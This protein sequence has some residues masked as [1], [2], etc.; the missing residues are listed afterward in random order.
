MK[1]LVC[2]LLGATML[3]G[4]AS[5]QDA[6]ELVAEA[7]IR[8]DTD[9]EGSARGLLR[10]AERS[11]DDDTDAQVRGDLALA[12]SQY[13]RWRR[14]WD[15]AADAAS[16]ATGHLTA[17]EAETDVLADAWYQA[18]YTRYRAGRI[19]DAYEAFSLALDLYEE[20]RDVFDPRRLRTNGWATLTREL[21]PRL[22]LA[23]EDPM[24]RV[25]IMASHAPAEDDVLRGEY[26][27]VWAMTDSPGF[28]ISAWHG[29]MDGFAVVLVDAGPDGVPVNLR[30][31]ESHPG[32]LWDIELERALRRWRL[33]LS[34]PDGRRTDIAITFVWAVQRYQR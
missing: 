33:D 32:D 23:E 24:Q 20:T 28:D 4:L 13:W 11:I 21:S 5:A 1:T 3:A 14:Q 16:L 17:S 8:L 22:E 29:R 7:Q 27:A 26:E 2:G 10:Q 31:L 18:G 9:R 25:F 15:R 34:E 12:W 19:A 6:A 30:I